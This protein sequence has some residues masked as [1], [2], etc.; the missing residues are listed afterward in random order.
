MARYALIVANGAYRD[1]KL[2]RLRTPTVDA[3]RL[4]DV[5][6]DPSIGDFDVD[7]A[8]DEPEH[9]L[10]RKVAGFFAG[11]DRD[12][13]LLLHFSCHGLKDESGQLYFA[14]A[15]TE[16]AQ[17]D[18]TALSAEFVSRQ[19]TRSRSRKVLALLDCCYSGAFARGLRFRGD[20]QVDLDDQLGGHGR[21]ILTASSAMEYAFEGEELTGTG[22]PSVF[23][24]AV[25][26]G[27][28][29]GEAD[30]DQDRRISV[31]ELYDYV[32]E[33]VRE[34]TPDQSPNM[35]SHLEG[36][37]YVARSSYVAPVAAAEL[38][39]ALREA[40]ESPFAGVRAGAVS[41]LAALADG[42]DAALA[43]GAR[44]ALRGLVEDDSR[45]VS[46][47]ARAALEPPAPPP[48]AA[49][50]APPPVA[51]PA[52]LKPK[53]VAA[54]AAPKP[55]AEPAAPKPVAE[56][57]APKPL[58]EPVAAEPAALPP[59]ARATEAGWRRP[60][61]LALVVVGALF[62]V[63]A[64]S[65]LATGDDARTVRDGRTAAAVAAGLAALL[66]TAR[67]VRLSPLLGRW[68]AVL[69][70]V[71]FGVGIAAEALEYRT[72]VAS[73]SEGLA[74]LGAL[75]ILVGG[76]LTPVQPVPPD[77]RPWR[78]VTAVLAGVVVLCT[79]L[80]W[81]GGETVWG[82]SGSRLGTFIVLGALIAAAGGFAGPGTSAPRPGVLRALAPGA[83]LA[84]AAMAFTIGGW[85][86]Y[87]SNSVGAGLD[88]T[89]FAGLA[90][91]ITGML[92]TR[93]VRAPA[94]SAA[95]PSS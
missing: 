6:R 2:S 57:A 52:A 21:V 72:S 27:L 93:P 25:V 16:V 44:A 9:V 85:A 73:F 64:V 90:I 24:T 15:D 32:C 45:R 59:P 28:E 43:E 68:I 70:G 30:R 26:K 65:A 63:Y 77:R 61:A 47:A 67:S 17:L 8:V 78:L 83:G 5:L 23:T 53:P 38:P 37:L 4:A 76:L 81:A 49:P 91:A 42:S 18:A 71:P 19:M 11:R 75:M 41:E 80:E 87:E 46:T 7:L 56:P 50:A 40:I 62:V 89:F 79:F 84:V 39:G 33:Q 29:T 95:R 74:V 66:A 86:D 60:A 31:D 1:P 22:N 36:A 82:A 55:V 58:A 94:G 69:S 20:E 48:I 12:D 54:P 35:L 51:E 10:R 92:A 34:I 14:A 88:L 3:E 13:L